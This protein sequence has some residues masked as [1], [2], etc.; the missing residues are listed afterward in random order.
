MEISEL[1]IHTKKNKASDLHISSLHPPVMRINGDMM[2]LKT[3]KL[4]PEDVKNLLF[5][6]MTE[7]QR[8]DYER[9]YE[10]DFAIQFGEDL[11]FRVNAFTTV[12]GPAATFRSISTKMSTLDEL[13]MPDILKKVSMLTKGLVL[14]T[15]PTGSG[16]STTLAAM[17]DYI[18]DH[19]AKHI[20]TIEDPVEFVHKSKRCLVNQR[21]LGSNTISFAR[22]LKSALREDPDVI[23]V[24]EL[25]DLETIQLA[26][27][28]AETGHLVMGTLHTSSAAK[29]I[30]RIIDVFPGQDK[31][32]IRSML[33]G[34]LEAV[35]AQRLIKTADDK[36]RVAGLEIL[37]GTPAVR[38]LVREGK[39]PQIYSLLQIGTKLGMRTMK[40]SVYALLE[41]G[42]ITAE[43]AKS[44]LN[45]QEELQ[46]P[47]SQGG[48]Q[49]ESPSTPVPQQGGIGGKDQSGDF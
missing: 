5:A 13:G 40:D 8:A 2:P 49:V 48:N 29:T 17:I 43:A 16:K 6:V 26:L 39:V 27:T 41:K 3:E 28:A 34:S 19:A 23:L 18:N 42:V 46:T 30:D 20:L 32:L 4:S 45:L 7:S 14:V 9:D 21:E 36:G 33:S 37:L 10:I 11:R 35:V 38:N 44:A 24:G 47:A 31:A 25:R 15:G 12:A 1:L 22:A